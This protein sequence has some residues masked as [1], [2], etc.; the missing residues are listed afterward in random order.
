MEG[1]LY[2][3][4][5]KV[6]KQKR[7][8]E[9]IEELE[10]IL[11][12]YEDL[13]ELSEF[14]P[15]IR[16][17]ISKHDTKSANKTMMMKNL[18]K[19]DEK[20]QQRESHQK[21]A[22]SI[23]IQIANGINKKQRS[24][25]QPEF[26]VKIVAMIMRHHDIGHTFLGHSGEWWL[27]NIGEDYGI[28]YYVHNA[29]GPR[30]LIYRYR[31]EEEISKK[32]E[33]NHP[34]ISKKKLARIKNSLWMVMEGINSH[35]GETPQTEYSPELSKT[36]KDFEEENLKCHT[37][38][39]F[40][41]TVVPATPE[42]CLAR[43]CDKI[44]YA[45]YDMVDGLREGFITE[46]NEEYISIL[47]KIGITEEEIKTANQN[48]IYDGIAKKI[49]QIW[50]QDT[51]K[52]SSNMCIKMSKEQ[53]DLQRQLVALNNKKIVDFVVLQE[54]N[55]TYPKCLRILMNAF[56]NLL[57]KEN[58]LS[59]LPEIYINPE[60]KKEIIEKYEHTP[61][62][63]FIKYTC[64]SNV[65]DLEYTTKIVEESTKQGILDEQEKARQIVSNGEDFKISEEFK[66]RDMRI[67]EYIEYY[68]TKNLENY[69]EQQ[70]EQDMIQV[71]ENIKNPNKTS[72]L[73][74]SPSKRIALEL[75]RKYLATLD[76]FEF[77]QLLVNTNLITDEQHKSLTRK[78]KDFDFRKEQDM[79]AN[80]IAISKKA[81]EQ[82]GAR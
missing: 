63:E 55:Q 18:R 2:K 58:F 39:G 52:N 70:K 33:Q 7:L 22:T 74:F 64:D 12:R 80:W 16:E 3:E 45:P 24:N 47:T 81:R 14:A 29:L 32:I 77:I 20:T 48:G 30:D 31:V 21:N 79:Q 68:K 82:G 27:S 43:L 36:K 9:Y 73:Y 25:G 26:N 71:L 51:I 62:Y 69:S 34:E 10:S 19:T 76:D 56:G 44:S 1:K 23:A 37:K 4:Q 40:D 6:I 17:E 13:K 8:S 65:K 49:Q 75:G 28:G 53:G 46:L 38:K 11:E 54:D 15:E 42:A 35:N 50:I 67:S 41:K 66:N 5:G 61:F 78:Y 57:L 59:K 72:P 60:Q